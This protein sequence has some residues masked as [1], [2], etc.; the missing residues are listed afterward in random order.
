MYFLGN[1]SSG[2]EVKGPGKIPVKKHL[3]TKPLATEDTELKEE[4]IDCKASQLNGPVQHKSAQQI[5]IKTF[6]PR[7]AYGWIWSLT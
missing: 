4:K 2:G 1:T 3:A 5:E 7:V 6:V